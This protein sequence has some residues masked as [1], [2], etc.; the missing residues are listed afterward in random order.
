MLP[1]KYTPKKDASVL[2]S[3]LY[4]SRFAEYRIEALLGKGAHF[5]FIALESVHELSP[6]VCQAGFAAVFSAVLARHD[7]IARLLLQAVDHVP[8]FLIRKP[9]MQA[10]L[11]DRL[12]ICNQEQQ[13]L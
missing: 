1:E 10:R 3:F 7:R 5:I 11:P 2:C 8:R 9:H 4:Q 13:Q 12:Q 6:L